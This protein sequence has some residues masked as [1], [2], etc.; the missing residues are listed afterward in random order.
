LSQKDYQI[1]KIQLLSKKNIIGLSVLVVVLFSV[2]TTFYLFDDFSIDKI[3]LLIITL[4][5]IMAIYLIYSYY[6][7]QVTEVITRVE[8]IEKDKAIQTQYHIDELKQLLTEQERIGRA[9]RESK[10]RFRHAAFHDFL[11]GLPNRDYFVQDL[12]V[13]LEKNKIDPNYKFAVLFLDLNRFKTINDSLGHSIGDKL[14]MNVAKRIQQAVKETDIVSRFGGDEFAII[15]KNISGIE[16][17]IQVSNQICQKIST[18]YTLSGKQVFA[19]TSIGISICNDNY[20][21]SEELLRDADIAMYF[22]K[23]R[24]E[25]YAVFNESMHVQAMEQIQLETDLRYAVA[26]NEFCLYYQPIVSIDE[27][28]LV[29]FEALMRWTHPEKGIVSP[30][31]FIPIAEETGLIIPMTL[32]VLREGCMQMN[33]WKKLSP[34]IENLTLSIN[35][36]GKHLAQR[37]L[38]EEIWKILKDTDYNPTCLKLEITESAVMENAEL[39]ISTLKELKELGVQLS[40]DDFGTGYSSL[41]YLHKFPIDILK[42]DRSFVSAMNDTSE[43]GEIVRTI[44]LLAKNLNMKVI[45]EGI[46]TIHQLHQLRILGCEFGQGFLFSKPVPAFEAVRLVTDYEHWKNVLPNEKIVT[47]IPDMPISINQTIQ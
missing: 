17:A 15:L 11:T 19:H 12:K 29:G 33:V 28:K 13:L 40:I 47:T 10:E 6:T 27:L 20:E 36:S 35:L 26:R 43:N 38:V 3:G 5:V 2:A 18:P 23:G 42:V 22:A 37:D 1:Q 4:V 24:G 14:L 41:S 31:Q 39:A 30:A 34:S 25:N 16:D 46:E 8:Q 45:A 44:V 32:W 9:L 7:K 21:H